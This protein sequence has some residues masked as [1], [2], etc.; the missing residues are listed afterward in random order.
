MRNKKHN[1]GKGSELPGK[2]T[3]LGHLPS[4]GGLP[5]KVEHV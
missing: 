4:S 1:K 3:A 5:K 2:I